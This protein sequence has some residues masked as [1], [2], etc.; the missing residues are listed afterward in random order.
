MV[1]GMGT[2]RRATG[3]GASSGDWQDER[4]IGR[5]RQD[6]ESGRRGDG[7]RGRGDAPGGAARGDPAPGDR[8]RRAPLARRIG[9]DEPGDDG[10]MRPVRTG[11]PGG[12]RGPDRRR[13]DPCHR[14]CRTGIDGGTPCPSRTRQPREEQVMSTLPAVSHQHHD[15]LYAIA[16][17]LHALSD[18]SDSDCMDTSRLIAAR[19]TIAEI[20][21]GLVDLP[22]P[23]Y[24]GGRGGRLPGPRA[25]CWPGRDRWGSCSMTTPRSG[26]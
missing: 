2:T 14:L 24:G 10:A 11:Y 16:D 7:R 3:I 26:S 19:P 4:R 17:Q 20:H 6:P 13:P 21:E 23:A 22:H 1:V 9:A 5:T 12:L 8:G 15:R 25:A 18:C